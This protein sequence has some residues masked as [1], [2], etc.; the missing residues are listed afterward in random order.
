MFA[1]LVFLYV[2]LIYCSLQFASLI[3]IYI[4]TEHTRVNYYD[5][6]D[7][8]CSVFKWVCL[9]FGIALVLLVA[10]Y[11]GV[12]IHFSSECST[13]NVPQSPPQ[14]KKLIN[15]N[16]TITI[17]RLMKRSTNASELPSICHTIDAFDSVLRDIDIVIIIIIICLGVIMSPCAA[18]AM[19]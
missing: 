1:K 6:F 8:F 17:V 10:T 5:S 14:E 16:G 2:K 3:F 11:I 19:G 4:H 9:A 15:T 7:R 12:H 13:G 18:M